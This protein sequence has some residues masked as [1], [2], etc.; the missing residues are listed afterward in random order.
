MGT[1][2]K[3]IRIFSALEIA[4]ICGV[5]NQTAINWIKNGFLKAFVTPGGQ[6]RVYA[7]DLYNFLQSRGMRIPYD[8][9][10][11]LK[12]NAMWKRVLIIDDDVSLNQMLKRSFSK[13]LPDHDIRQAFDG[14]EAGRIIADWNPGIIVLDIDLPGIDGYTLC[15]KIKTDPELGNPV[16]IAITGL[17]DAQEERILKDGAD[18]FWVKPFDARD[19]AQAIQVKVSERQT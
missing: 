19:L 18:D 9:N 6:Y 11:A 2:D 5:V 12:N 15:K 1:K 8:L 10:Q 17:L 13:L 14:F 16:V 3:R 4:N 7:E